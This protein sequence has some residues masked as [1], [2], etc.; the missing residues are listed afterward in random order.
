MDVR[1]NKPGGLVGWVFEI[2]KGGRGE[3]NYIRKHKK[4]Y[5]IIKKRGGGNGLGMEIL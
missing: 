4:K 5:K 1:N 2:R 3:S